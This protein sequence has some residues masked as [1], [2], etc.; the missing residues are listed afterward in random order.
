MRIR[1]WQRLFLLIAL[2]GITGLGAA[3]I[4]QQMQFERGFLAYVNQ[5]SLQQWEAGAGRLA[6]YYREQKGWDSLRGNRRKFDNIVNGRA[7]SADDSRERG[8]RPPPPPH[9]DGRPMLPMNEPGSLRSRPS[10]PPDGPTR[11]GRPMLPMDEPGSL[12]SRPSPPP[13]GPTRMM[14][15]DATGARVAGSREVPADSSA[16]PVTV[17]GAIVGRLLVAP[18][19]A[20]KRGVDIE[21]A[22][23][24]GMYAVI[25][26]VGV[27]LIALICAWLSAR[28]LQKP[29]GSLA[30][31]TR[32]LAEGNYE[33]DILV[34]RSDE[35][36]DLAR[37]FGRL[38][39]A[40]R[41]NRDARR[42]WGA[43]IAHELRTP[44][45]ILGGELQ[46]LQA[47]IRPFTREALDSLNAECQ[48]LGSL[49]EDLYQLSLSD[50]GA[51]EYR[52]IQTD[53]TAI[54]HSAVDLHRHALQE[55]GLDISVSLLPSSG[56]WLKGDERRLMQLFTNLFANSRRYTDAPG[57]VAISAGRDGA[58]WRIIFEDTAPG[59][60]PEHLPKL[61]ERL[62]RV[63]ASRDRAEGGAGLGL[64]IARSIVDA[65]GG[66]IAASTSSL[67]GLRIT[68]TFPI[69]EF[70]ERAVVPGTGHTT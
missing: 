40:L 33:V 45:S 53:L 59:V 51:L 4:V 55:C 2:T 9:D 61:F 35:L 58:D 47:G 3:L 24:Q 54:I 15:V 14:L 28:N 70:A 56:M 38:A 48:R 19:P 21:F 10:P 31:G 69:V 39:T 65:H 63:D 67:G 27:M 18:L 57:R 36:G 66:R 22:R 62:Y 60:A 43:D 12:K 46:A 44:L 41:D 5:L 37:D 23:S 8:D 17:G 6:D 30:T 29:I 50:A 52:L 16:L 13:D 1:L 49:V 25:I 64:S 34:T 20:L 11:D 68:V 42:R 26:G 7:S 32:A